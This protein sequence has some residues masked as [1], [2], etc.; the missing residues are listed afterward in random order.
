MTTNSIPESWDDIFQW[1]WTTGTTEFVPYEKDGRLWYY[2]I[3]QEEN[4]VNWLD[5][6]GNRFYMFNSFKRVAANPHYNFCGPKIPPLSPV[7][8]KI[9]QMEQRF[10]ARTCCV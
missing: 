9:R 6:R 8:K 5:L 4:P 10:R 3:G 2:I 1:T 7:I